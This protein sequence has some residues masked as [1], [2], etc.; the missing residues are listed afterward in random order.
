MILE[1]QRLAGTFYSLFFFFFQLKFIGEVMLVGIM[2]F[3]V[4]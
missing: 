2:P 3:S 4:Y 1:L